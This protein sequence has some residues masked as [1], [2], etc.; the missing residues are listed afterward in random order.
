MRQSLAF[1]AICGIAT[2]AAALV[3]QVHGVHA[4]A[5]A[6]E[7]A[8]A[9]QSARRPN[10]LL[11]VTDDQRPDTIHALGNTAIR[12]PNLDRL[13]DR[14]TSF[15]RAVCAYPICHVSRAEMLTGCTAFR[16]IQPYPAGK[17]NDAL[18]RL[19]D[20]L[21]DAGYQTCYVGK[22]HTTG[23]P[24]TRG[25][26]EAFGLFASGGNL[27][28]TYPLDRFGKPHTGYRGW[29]FQTDEGMK[30]PEQGVG[31][32]PDTD[33]EIATGAIDF[34]LDR[35]DRKKDGPLTPCFLNVNFSA[36]RERRMAPRF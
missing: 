17:L 22:W 31:L 8:A 18:P 28:L 26:E 27:P 32:T 20:V 30:L 10:V 24:S 11:I 16:A 7:P 14:G 29:V 19:S 6:T 34:L 35:D 23:R 3:A 5:P 36:P 13:V 9:A 15:T 21:R 1:R 2:F 33:A 4:Q 12:T 25:Y